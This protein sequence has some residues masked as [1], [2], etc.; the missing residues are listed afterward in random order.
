MHKLQKIYYLTLWA[1][2]FAPSLVLAGWTPGEPIVPECAVVATDINKDGCHFTDLITL[3]D[4]LL[5]VFIWIAIPVSTLLFAWIGWT[6]IVSDK[7][8][9]KSE[10]RRKLTTL[11]RGLFFVLAPWI[12]VKLIVSGL[13]G[14]T[15][16]LN[17]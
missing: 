16:I 14:D 11:L 17:P 9:A 7:A 5:Y 8:S 15:S 1:V 4:N 3:I 2:L 12:I 6:L 10:A 13:G